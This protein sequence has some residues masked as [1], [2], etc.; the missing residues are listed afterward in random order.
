MS[1]FKKI[2]AK[3]TG[4]SF[5]VLKPRKEPGQR[6]AMTEF[7]TRHPEPPPTAEQRFRAQT[8]E[9]S[10]LAEERRRNIVEHRAQEPKERTQ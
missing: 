8:E 1:V 6:D 2:I 4:A 5:E 3:L 7:R 10:R 9:E